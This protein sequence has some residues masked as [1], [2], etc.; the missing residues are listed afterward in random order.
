[1][2]GCTVLAAQKRRPGFSECKAITDPGN[3]LALGCRVWGF[4]WLSDDGGLLYRFSTG[5]FGK[6]LYPNICG[7][8]T[9]TLRSKYPV[10]EYLGSWYRTVVQV[11]G[12]VSRSHAG[13]LNPK[14]EQLLYLPSGCLDCL[15]GAWGNLIS[16]RSWFRNVGSIRPYCAHS[17]FKS[18][19]CTEIDYIY[20]FQVRTG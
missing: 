14:P 1:M 11:L 8:D 15:M 7:K 12:T 19:R 20:I 4:E 3:A 9:T 6:A 18:Y 2:L 13:C 17:P 10:F 5:G 16:A